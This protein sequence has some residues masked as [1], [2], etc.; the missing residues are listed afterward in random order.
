MLTT[1]RQDSNS[2]YVKQV[3]K[4]V[5]AAEGEHPACDSYLSCLP[6]ACHVMSTGCVCCTGGYQDCLQPGY[7]VCRGIREVA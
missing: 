3:R 7:M 4:G 5:L 2:V 6:Y 1:C